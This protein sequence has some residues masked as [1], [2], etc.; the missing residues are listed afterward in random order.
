MTIFPRRRRGDCGKTPDSPLTSP[1]SP[2]SR[3]AVGLGRLLEQPTLVRHA[4]CQSAPLRAQRLCVA[5]R[6]R[7]RSF[8]RSTCNG[9]ADAAR[10]VVRPLGRCSLPIL[11][12]LAIDGSREPRRSGPADQRRRHGKI[13]ATFN[14][15]AQSDLARNA[16]QRWHLH[17]MLLRHRSSLLCTRGT[18]ATHAARPTPDAGLRGCSS[19]R[20]WKHTGATDADRPIALS[21]PSV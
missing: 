3:H 18:A 1:P 15:R 21:C 2:V 20:Y 12:E 6:R 10:P 7:G 17:P 19:G 9:T 11:I 8:R 16:S 4:C 14:R 5:S 13:N